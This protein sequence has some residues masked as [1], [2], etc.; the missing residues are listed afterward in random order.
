MV[1][2]T[3]RSDDPGARYIVPLLSQL[4]WCNFSR[5]CTSPSDFFPWEV[6]YGRAVFGTA[7]S[8]AGGVSDLTWVVQRDAGAFDSIRSAVCQ[9]AVDA[10]AAGLFGQLRRGLVRAGATQ[11]ERNDRLFPRPGSAGSATIHWIPGMGPPAARC[12]VGRASGDRIGRA[13][14]RVGSR[15][16][17]VRQAGNRIGGRATTMERPAGKNRQ[18][19]S[20]RVFGLRLAS[21]AGAGRFAPVPSEAVDQG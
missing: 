13:R 17:G 1:A 14:G 2:D 20:G 21:G 7:E 11:D 10:R 18:Q 9:R 12:A 4:A 6:F 8:H 16:V 15:P 3:Q 5:L 19:P